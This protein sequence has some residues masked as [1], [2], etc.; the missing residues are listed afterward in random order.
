M[1]RRASAILPPGVFHWRKMA[2]A[3]LPKRGPS[4]VTRPSRPLLWLTRPQVH[5]LGCSHC[6]HTDRF[7]KRESL[8][9]RLLFPLGKLGICTHTFALSAHPKRSF[10][11]GTLF[12]TQKQARRR[13]WSPPGARVVRRTRLRV[14]DGQ[15]EA[16][17]L[18][19]GCR[20]DH[21]RRRQVGHFVGVDGG[22]AYCE[23][24]PHNPQ[25][26]A[27]GT[28]VR[29]RVI[30]LV[31]F[32]REGCRVREGFQVLAEC[33]VR[34]GGTVPDYRDRHGPGGKTRERQTAETAGPTCGPASPPQ[35]RGR[36]SVARFPRALESL[37][38]TATW[39]GLRC[40][41]GASR[42]SCTGL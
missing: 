4:T 21:V 6:R 2:H 10:F 32:P 23:R 33:Y 27:C 30:I 12:L 20:F 28:G 36:S 7:F 41:R 17:R 25:C 31:G 39:A 15:N 9:L 26:Y 3:P 29:H 1:L 38:R 5:P 19:T 8:R 37:R 40:S 42:D 22:R 34:L 35:S 13:V 16:Q 11:W 24:C 14:R 18:P